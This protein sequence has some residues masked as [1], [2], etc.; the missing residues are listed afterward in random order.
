MKNI[1]RLLLLAIIFTSCE[2]VEPTIYNGEEGNPTFLSFSQTRYSLPVERDGV[3]SSQIVLNSSTI[4]SVDRTYNLAVIPSTSQFAA[5]PATY[6]LPTSITIPAGQYQGFATLTGTD[7]AG[8]TADTRSF[9]FQ[10]TNITTENFDSNVVNVDVFEACAL[11]SSFTGTYNVTQITPNFAVADDSAIK[12]GQIT[13]EEGAT[14][15]DRVFETSPYPSYGLP[16][17]DFI[18]TFLCDGTRFGSGSVDTQIGCTAGANIFLAAGNTFGT[19][20]TD[21]DSVFEVV[22]TENATSTCGTGPI[23][24][25]L[26]FT[27]VN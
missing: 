26:R 23:Q 9:A 18:I 16:A 3:G 15:Y 20:N 25:R 22:I 7:N 24:T 19:Y 10:I 13:L 21:D 1:F 14:I 4:S 5:D 12:L 11:N 6:N 17:F 8:V 27:K 2:D